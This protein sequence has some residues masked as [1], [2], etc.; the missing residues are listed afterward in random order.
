[1]KK[2]RVGVFLTYRCLA[3][4]L[5]F[6]SPQAANLSNAR[7][8]CKT[9]PNRLSVSTREFFPISP[10]SYHISP[11]FSLLPIDF[12]AAKNR[13]TPPEARLSFEPDQLPRRQL[14]EQIETPMT[15]RIPRRKCFDPPRRTAF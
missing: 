10:N 11:L 14:H 13:R 9:L 6:R 5:L 15:M 1:M 7:R 8:P 2:F 3:D 4:S 12:F